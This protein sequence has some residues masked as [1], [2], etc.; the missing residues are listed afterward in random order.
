MAS[1]A[2]FKLTMGLEGAATIITGLNS[3]VDLTKKVVEVV[4]KSAEAVKQLADEAHVYRQAIESHAVSVGAAERATAGLI[5]TVE[6][7]R[8]AARLEAEGVRVTEEQLRSLAVASTEYARRSGKDVTEA[9]EE[10]TDAVIEAEAEGMRPYGVAVREGSTQA[11]RQ[12]QVLA[13]LTRRYADQTVAVEDTSEAI[14]VLEH[15]WASAWAE[16]VLTLEREGGLIREIVEGIT[17]VLQDV[18]NALETQRRAQTGLRVSG[19]LDEQ[20]ELLRRRDVAAAVL[21]ASGVS[22]SE[23][24]TYSGREVA[25]VQEAV[26]ARRLSASGPGGPRRLRGPEGVSRELGVEEATAL[27][28]YRDLQMQLDDVA[29]RITEAEQVREEERTRQPQPTPPPR[30]E[31][32]GAAP[33]PETPEYIQDL[34]DLGEDYQEQQVRLREKTLDDEARIAA[35]RERAYEMMAEEAEAASNRAQKAAD[36]QVAAQER[37]N[38]AIEASAKPYENAISRLETLGDVTSGLGGVFNEIS[39]I[40]EL[41]ADADEK[42]VERMKKVKGAFLLAEAIVQAAIEAARAAASFASQ[43][44][45]GGALHTIAAAMFVAAAVKAGVELGAS[46]K[47]GTSTS[48]ST[49]ARHEF[50][51]PGGGPRGESQRPPVVVYINGNVTSEQVNEDLRRLE[52]DGSRGYD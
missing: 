10:L 28:E 45:S 14:S 51:A 50:S 15:T 12:Q 5:E 39:G 7:H 21:E 22:P 2:D 43:D 40:I 4:V 27:A 13:E 35:E 49:G 16:M 26:R 47:S 20:A 6:L 18:T 48:A 44:Y 31:G 42:S 24:A 11:Q 8:Q 36:D 25:D 33:E 1:K 30:R 19:L 46:S 32:G 38:Q 41:T 37:V 34:I 29:Q 17:T 3:L 23:A 9:F 52:Q